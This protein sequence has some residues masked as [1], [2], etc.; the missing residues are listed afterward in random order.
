MAQPDC[1]SQA[2][3]AGD[4]PGIGAG[5][6]RRLDLTLPLPRLVEAAQ[7]AGLLPPELGPVE[8]A[9]LFD[10]FRTTRQALDRYRPAPYPGHLTLL[11]ASRRP[12]ATAAVDPAATWAAMASGGS[13]LELLPGDHYSIVRSPAVA[14]LAAALRR[15]LAAANGRPRPARMSR[16]GSQ[17]NAAAAGQTDD[18]SLMELPRR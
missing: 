14:A 5:I 12:A 7:A 4:H 1:G 18:P 2:T 10:L 6:S 8:V 3:L 13:E 9:R 16:A 11:L 15:R 17:R